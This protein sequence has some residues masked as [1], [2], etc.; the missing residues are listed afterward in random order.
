MRSGQRRRKTGQTSFLAPI[1]AIILMLSMP[2]SASLDLR[3]N[4]QPA[5][6]NGIIWGGSGSVDT[7]W[8]TVGSDNNGTSTTIIQHPPGASISNL[9]FEIGVNGSRGVCAQDP[10]LTLVD[11]NQAIFDGSGIGGFGCNLAYTPDPIIDGYMDPYSNSDSGFLLPSGAELTDLVI[12]ALRPASPRLSS[13]TPSMSIHDTSYDPST[14]R[15]FLLVDDDLLVIDEDVSTPIVHVEEI[16]GRALQVLPSEDLLLV[17]DHAG[18]LS[19]YKLSNTELKS[20]HN[21]STVV[22]STA[23]PLS[24]NATIQTQIYSGQD[25]F[26]WVVHGC[27]VL[28]REMG[29]ALDTWYNRN[30]CING[31]KLSISSVFFSHQTLYLGTAGDGLLTF[32]YTTDTNGNPDLMNQTIYNTESSQALVSDSI[33]YILM[34]GDQILIAGNGGVDRLHIPSQTWLSPWTVAN[35]LDSNEVSTLIRTDNFLHVVTPAK[36]HRYDTRVLAFDGDITPSQVNQTQFISAFDWPTSQHGIVTSDGSGSLSRIVD[37]VPVEPLVIASGPSILNPNVVSVIDTPSGKQSWF[38]KDSEI[39]RFDEESKRWLGA[40]DFASDGITSEI[41]DIVQID[42]SIVLVST[43]GHGILQLD[44]SSGDLLGTISGSD[45]AGINEMVFDEATNLVFVSM[46]EFGIAI[47]NSTDFDDYVFY[48]EDSGLDSLEFT[49]MAS[50]SDIL[51]IGTSDAGV[52]RIEISTETVLPSWRSLGIDDVEEAPIAY[53]DR[54]DTIFL[55]LKGFGVIILDRFTGQVLHIWDQADGS[56]PDDDVNDLHVDI[57]GDLII[58]TEGPSWFNPGIAALWDG[59]DYIQPSWTSFPTS[60]PGR[61]NDPYQ[62]F[63]ATTNTD[64]IY[65]GTNRGACMWDWA[66]NGPDCW[67]TDDGLPSRFVNTVSI[68]DQNRLYAGTSEGAAIIDTSTGTLVDLWTAA[69]DS[70][71]TDVVRVG[72]VV[73]L[74]VQETGIARYDTIAE[75]W[76]TTWDGTAGIIDNEFITMLKEG[77]EP[78]TLWAGGYF[79]LVLINTTSSTVVVDWNLGQN[80]DG[81]T[82]PNQPPVDIITHTGILYYQQITPSQSWQTRDT[83]FRIDL[84]NNTTLSSIDT[85]DSLGYQGQIRGMHLVQDSLWLGVSG[86]QTWTGSESGDIARWNTSTEDW[87]DSIGSYGGVQRVN[88]EFLGDCFPVASNNCELWVAYG[89][90]ILRRYNATDMTLIESWEDIPGPIRGIESIGETYYFGSMDGILRWSA[91]NSTF[92]TPLVPGDGMPSNVADRV[93]SMLTVGDDLWVGTYQGGNI[94]VSLYNSTQATWDVTPYSDLGGYAY[95]ADFELCNDIIHVA[96]GR[97]QW[98]QGGYVARFDYSDSDGN[99]I[100]GEWIDSWED[101]DGLEDSDPRALACDEDHP[102]LYTGYDSDNVGISR[103]DYDSGLVAP[104][105]TT[106]SGISSEPVFPGGMLHDNGLLIVSHVDEGGISRLETSGSNF[107]TGTVLGVGMDGSSIVRAPP[108]SDSAYAIGRS[109]ETSINRVDRLDGTGLIEGGFDE[110]LILPSGDVVEYASR[111]AEVW[112]AVGR[113]NQGGWQS[114]SGYGQTILEGVV[115]QGGNVSWTYSYNLNDDILEDMFLDGDTLWLST[116]YRGLMSLDLS[117]RQIRSYPGLIHDSIDG[118]FLDGTDLY[119]GL[120][121]L[122]DAASGFQMLDTT[123]R[124]WAEPELL[125]SLPANDIGDFE[126]IG[127][128]T[129][130]STSVGLG[131]FDESTSEWLDPITIYDGLP[132]QSDQL[133]WI[134]NTTYG[135]TLVVSSPTGLSYITNPGQNATVIGR[136]TQSDGLVSSFISSMTLAPAKSKNI[137][138]ADGQVVQIYQPRVLLASH[139]G[140]GSSRPWISSWSIDSGSL[141]RDYPLDMLP[142]NTVTSIA[143]DIWGIHIATD[144]GPL[145]HYNATSFSME[146]G[147][148]SGTLASWPVTNLVSDGTRLVSSG[149]GFSIIGV[150]DHVPR[151]YDPAL[152]ST[153]NDMEIYGS[154]LVLATSEGALAYRPYWAL[155]RLYVDEYSRAENLEFTFMGS[156]YDIT[157]QARPGNPVRIPTSEII[158]DSLLQTGVQNFGSIPFS[159]HPAIFSSTIAAQPVWSEAQEL[160]YTGSWNLSTQ[161]GLQQLLQLAVDTAGSPSN[162]NWEFALS[163]PESGSIEIKIQ[164]DWVRQE[165]P[166]SITLFE[167]RPKDAGDGLVINWEIA[168]DPSFI[169]YELYV[170]HA[171]TGWDV[172]YL[173]SG[174]HTEINPVASISDLRTLGATIDQAYMGNSLQDIQPNEEYFAA[175]SIRYPDGSLGPISIFGASATPIDNIPEAP[176]FLHAQPIGFSGGSLLVEWQPCTDLDK[177][178]TRVWYSTVEIIDVEVIPTYV[179]ISFALGNQTIVDVPPSVPIWLAASCVDEAGQYDSENP[180]LFGP[181]VAAGGLDDSIPPMRVN[182]VTASD[183]PFDDGGYLEVT[184]TP[185]EEEDC[186]LYY[187]HILPASGFSPPT[188]AEG[189]P[190]ADVVSGCE[191]SY[192]IIGAGDGNQLQNSVRYWVAVIAYDDWGNGDLNNVLPDDATPFDNLGSEG[193]EPARITDIAAFDHP[194]DDGTSIDV[195]WSRSEAPDFAYYTIWVSEHP[196]DSVASLWFFCSES[197]E[198]CGLRTIQQRQIGGSQKVELQLSEALYGTSLT[199]SASLPITP[200]IPLYVAV[201]VHDLSGNVHLEDLNTALV[202]PQSN[203]EDTNPPDRIPAPQ[204]IDRDPDH[205]DGMFILFEPSQ[206]PDISSYEVYA[207]Q[208]SPFLLTNLGDTTPSAILPRDWSGIA[209]IEFSTGSDGK[210]ELMP[211]RRYYVSI[212][213]RDSNGNAWTSDLE[214]SDIILTDELGLDPCPACPDVSGL[215]AY[216]NPSGSRIVLEWSE[217]SDQNVIGYHVYAAKTPFSDV[218]DASVIALD[219]TVTQFGFDSMDDRPLNRTINHYVEVVAYDGEKFT[220]RASPVM[221]LPWTEQLGSIDSEVSDGDSVIDLLV[222]GDLNILLGTIIF[223]LAAIGAAFTFRSRRTSVDDLWEISTREVEIDAL[224]DDDIK[225]GTEAKETVEIPIKPISEINTPSESDLSVEMDDLDDLARDLDDLI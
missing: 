40:R 205:G 120:T 31:E 87:E 176:T 166:T 189:W 187:I 64:G 47:G 141:L 106:S 157:D 19:S 179:D 191:N 82:L 175:V 131:R 202:L 98:W 108:E 20:T 67:S 55:G 46:P 24:W 170:W 101:G 200:Q 48:D 62:F 5:E 2:W 124:I 159:W 43:T 35:W 8:I 195:V 192:A 80:T 173:E 95:P 65:M 13:S 151:S 199:D 100:S 197:P 51:F 50:R 190:V 63:E 114:S 213:A 18:L 57:N 182:G 53:F 81:P 109:G 16:A 216:W 70:D 15:M 180:A 208:D 36:I 107:Q 125:A 150:E 77:D 73:Y 119:T 130:I 178:S 194:S 222:N 22:T 188:S 23:A 27:H 17:I 154:T 104:T 215:S 218:R 111:G 4:H 225:S 214:S 28:W 177:H 112:V 211:D 223:G 146:V 86:V 105:I 3:E 133:E 83:V 165:I 167:D 174:G 163:P 33:T 156:T 60:I 79:G 66:F 127:N 138:I 37:M 110:L 144:T 134:T 155:E 91:N 9:S 121:S 162:A 118:L 153:V 1:I 122:L 78:G 93:Y 136:T 90:S 221:V 137:T 113:S 41:T 6:T 44:S 185:N 206:A 172:D 186:V 149:T 68:L 207:V 61:N 58:S 115:S 103:F 198:S 152:N 76:L 21:L 132:G 126:R 142:S 203:L 25:N 75:D 212:V 92:L 99:G 89:D 12:Q 135:D 49:A 14:D 139:P 168:E 209:L 140:F 201:T 85:T 181:L 158:Q 184:W 94:D 160:N 52:I 210:T 183:L 164:Y 171:S 123:T 84:N 220:Y 148:S 72:S 129:Y 116:T 143:T 147:P 71:Q 59:S 74:G 54:D 69:A 128:I 219:R 42:T 169:S 30:I 97:L 29:M 88:A 161:T 196:L 204:L 34:M 10:I 56:L 38:A 26:T 32:D 7:G 193:P 39:D 11:A 224:F 117:T 102:M 217:S 45:V 96:F 145:Y